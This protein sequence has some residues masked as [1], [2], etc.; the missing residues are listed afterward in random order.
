METKNSAKKPKIKICGL[1]REE[2]IS[3]VNEAKPDYIGFVFAPSRRQV[4]PEEARR[5]REKLKDEITS[6]GVFVNQ[7]I[8]EILALYR[9]RVIRMIQ[10]HGKED[11]A[12]ITALKDQCPAP[13]IKAFRA[14]ALRDLKGLHTQADFTLFDNG[15][16]G[17]GQT[18]DWSLLPA[19]WDTPPWFLAGGINLGTIDHALR[20]K[21][22]C[23]DVSTGAETN[24]IKDRQKILALVQRVRSLQE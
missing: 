4:S 24:G 16:G 18:F 23:I 2:D 5:L 13:I 11:E 17:T 8:D 3:F 9:A 21:P 7:P 20:L 14:D 1:F 10:L 19:A 22:Y 6:V 15:S 12:Y